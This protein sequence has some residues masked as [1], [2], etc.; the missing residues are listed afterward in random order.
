MLYLRANPLRIKSVTYH[1]IKHR[2]LAHCRSSSVYSRRSSVGIA[3]EKL[4]DVDGDAAKRK[5]DEFRVAAQQP[6]I[7]HFQVQAF[8][9][10]QNYVESI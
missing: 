1:L 8:K 4:C 5:R 7:S 6:D 9:L 2:F 10:K 3:T